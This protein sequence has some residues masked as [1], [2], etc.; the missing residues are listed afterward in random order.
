MSDCGHTE[1]TADPE[2]EGW[3]NVTEPVVVILHCHACGKAARVTV[4]D[5][6]LLPWTDDPWGQT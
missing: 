6:A 5:V 4:E 3:E 1:I 2:V